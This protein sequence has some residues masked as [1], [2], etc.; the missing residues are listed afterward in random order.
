MDVCSLVHYR[1]DIATPVIV[2]FTLIV[3]SLAS[4]DLRLTPN[5]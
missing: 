5:P 4:Q 2:A 1:D 3:H